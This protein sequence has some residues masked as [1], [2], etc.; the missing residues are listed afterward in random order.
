MSRPFAYQ[1]NLI[2][3]DEVC[4]ECC[5]ML[6]P[7]CAE[8][9]VCVDDIDAVADELHDAIY[10]MFNEDQQFYILR[11]AAE[12]SDILDYIWSNDAENIQQFCVSYNESDDDSSDFMEGDLNCCVDFYAVDGMICINAGCDLGDDCSM[13]IVPVEWNG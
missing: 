11:Q 4:S 1:N 9:Y 13:V 7:M 6:Q 8:D 12:T 2:D 10:D 5:A 3:I